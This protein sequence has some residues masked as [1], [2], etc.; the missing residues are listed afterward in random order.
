MEEKPKFIKRKLPLMGQH[1]T[2]NDVSVT[3]EVAL[4]EFYDCAYL[5]QNSNS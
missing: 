2:G 5:G 1:N 4:A 3:L